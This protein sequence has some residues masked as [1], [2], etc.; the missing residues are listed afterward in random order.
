MPN[1]KPNGLGVVEKSWYSYHD[2]GN[3]DVYDVG[4]Y[5]EDSRSGI[6]NMPGHT[7]RVDNDNANP[8]RLSMILLFSD[9][10]CF[11]FTNF[12]NSSGSFL[13]SNDV[14]TVDE[15]IALHIFEIE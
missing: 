3:N 14:V 15:E 5:E 13:L 12:F 1:D 2:D 7:S 8:R 6:V 4:L 9:L 11:K 10:N